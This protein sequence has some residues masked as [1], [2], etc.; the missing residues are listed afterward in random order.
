M[1][2]RRRIFDRDDW[3]C[4]TCGVYGTERTLRADHIQPLSQGG[5]DHAANMQ[6]L[7]MACHDAKSAA[8]RGHESR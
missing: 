1:T 2:R 8:E 6:T 5:A 7:C 4:K 3:R